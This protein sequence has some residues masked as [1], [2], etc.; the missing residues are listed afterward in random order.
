M[1]YFP[2]T[3][4]IKDTEGTKWLVYYIMNGELDKG[5]L[6]ATL[7]SKHKTMDVPDLNVRIRQC[8][9]SGFLEHAIS[10]SAGGDSERWIALVG[11]VGCQ[12]LS[13]RQSLFELRSSH[14]ASGVGDRVTWKQR[15]KTL[16]CHLTEMYVVRWRRLSTGEQVQLANPKVNLL[17]G[18]TFENNCKAHCIHYLAA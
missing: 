6:Q 15:D 1:T 14:S 11:G 9:A 17:L 18:P 4:S 7:A 16:F 2:I 13:Q 3:T 10:I 8:A 12:V 5:G